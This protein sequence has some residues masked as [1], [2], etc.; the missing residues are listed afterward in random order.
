MKAPS[1]ADR[2][3]KVHHVLRQRAA[4]GASYAERTEATA[5]ATVHPDD[6]LARLDAVVKRMPA[7]E[8]GDP[9]EFKDS[10]QKL[11]EHGEPALRKLLQPATP[12]DSELSSD[13]LVSLE[14]VIIADGSR[15]SFLLSEGEFALDHP[16]LGN[17]KGD[18]TNFRPALRK[19]AGCV[20][21]IQLPDGGPTSYNGTGTLVDAA[22]CLVLTNYHVVKHARN[23]SGVTMEG[24]AKQLKV[25]DDWVID[26]IGETGSLQKNRWRV[27]EVRLP[28]GVGVSFEGVDAAVLHIEPFDTHESRLP[29]PAIVLSG[30]ANYATGAGTPTLATIGFPGQPNIITPPG[31]TVDWNFVIKTLFNNL[32]GLKRV[33]PGEF[34]KA[35]GSVAD[36]HLGHVL[37]HDATTFGGAS[38]SLVFAWK[39][40][41]DPAFALHFAGATLAANYA[42]SL[43]KA[44]AALQAVGVPIV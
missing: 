32:F 28:A 19:L 42:V 44:K 5:A 7:N 2:I 26:F 20:G 15:P 40:D 34:D 33:A 24:D 16:F 14:A 43:H 30:D 23:V 17:W 39:D 21:R 22:N 25:K 12:T 36:D 41:K 11:V 10:L 37:S 27:K 18:M 4:R 35:I 9:A 29:E 3:R 38:G 8:V 6:V 1:P 13:Q 31:A